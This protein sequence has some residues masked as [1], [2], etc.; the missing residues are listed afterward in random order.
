MLNKKLQIF[1]MLMGMTSLISITLSKNGHS[2]F[3]PIGYILAYAIC[4]LIM[5]NLTVRKYHVMK[6][7]AEF[8]NERQI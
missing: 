2:E 3:A 7:G 4:A 6:Y 1:I 5:L 8:T